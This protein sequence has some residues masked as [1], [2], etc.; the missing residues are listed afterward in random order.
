MLSYNKAKE[1]FIFSYTS[2]DDSP[3]FS[4]LDCEQNINFHSDPLNVVKEKLTGLHR[5]IPCSTM[6]SILVHPGSIPSGPMHASP[7]TWNYPHIA[8][9][10]FLS[11]KGISTSKCIQELG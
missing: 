10:R 5:F 1:Q 2:S 4:I 3:S 9:I 11:L 7:D 8:N 6:S